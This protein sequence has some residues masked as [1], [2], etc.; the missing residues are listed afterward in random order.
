MATLPASGYIPNASR[1]TAEQKVALEA[2]RHI[3]AESIGGEARATKTIASG[4]IT[5]SEGAGGGIIKLDTEAAAASDTLDTIST[6]NT[7]DGQV[8]IIMAENAA[9]VVTVNHGFGGTGQILLQD[10]VDFVF[11]SLNAWIM[12]QRRSTDWVELMRW[13][14]VSD[15]TAITTYDTGDLIEVYDSSATTKKK[16]A[17][18]DLMNNVGYLNV[19]QNSQ[20][21]AYTLVLA[22]AGKHIL[23]PST[24]A[25]ARTFTIPANASVAFPVGTTVTFVNETSQNVTI[26]IT[27]D[28]LTLAGTTTTG[29]RTLGQN[30]VA[31]AIKVTSTKWII[32]GTG[33]T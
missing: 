9:R 16:L 2:L 8:I 30:G 27:T 12:L 13:V 32:S 18:T 21:A 3:L 25:N 1:T 5:L 10:S 24:D 28:T 23:H 15:M 4:A 19:P 14:P 33:L 11:A 6:T 7:R 22:D 26:A 31:T 17:L 20:S 29:S